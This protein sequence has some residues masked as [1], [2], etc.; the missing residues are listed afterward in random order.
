MMAYRLKPSRHFTDE[1]HRIAGQ[2]LAKAIEALETQP[3]GISDAI[4]AA[5]RCLKKTRALY[6]LAA[7]QAKA[8]YRAENA[9]LRAAQRSVA[10]LRDATA[11]VATAETLKA[12]LSGEEEAAAERA[13]EALRVRKTW[14]V[15]A[16]TD[17]QGKIDALIETLRKARSAVKEETF[18]KG[19]RPTAHMIAAAWRK[20]VERAQIALATCH[21]RPTPDHLHDLRK[22]VQDH[23]FYHL[24]LQAA[25]PGVILARE[26]QVKALIDRLGFIHD[27]S[28]L[29]ETLAREPELLPPQ[30]IAI[31]RHAIGLEMKTEERHGLAEA[32]GL[33]SDA[34]GKEAERIAILWLAAA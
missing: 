6:R 26:R 12:R 2:Q 28:V 4:H 13:V 15:T 27:L 5:R 33:F 1:F 7:P 29:A 19:A 25:W 16:E 32:D 34:A 30:D 14:V 11:L 17:M 20:S 31:L 23:R 22:R 3:D 9:R 10:D 21:E 8:F 18:E 24:L